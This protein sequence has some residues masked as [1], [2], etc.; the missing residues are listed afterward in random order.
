[1]STQYEALKAPELY[2]SAFQVEPPAEMGERKMTPRRP[3]FFIT[4]SLT[5]STD[6]EN[7][8]RKAALAEQAAAQAAQ[9]GP[10]DEPAP[11]PAAAPAPHDTPRLLVPAQWGLVPHWVKSASDGQLRAT[12]LVNV[13]SD[14]AS[15]S[16]AFRDAW[17]NNQRC[18]VPMMAFVTDD[19]RNGKAKPTRIARVD[20]LPMGVAGVWSRW[21]DEDGTELLSYAIITVNANAHALMNRYQQ[22]GNEKSMPAI[23]NEGA[24]DAWLRSSAYKAKEFLRAY[25]AQKLLANPVEKGR[26]NPLGI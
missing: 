15:T 8:A 26:K 17:L 22:P 12:K 7:S 4:T 23:L 18:I 1:M 19:Y 11:T 3:G 16:T 2:L 13:K 25:P 6:A 20:G 21:T 9:D 5:G 24:Y 10:A 14:N